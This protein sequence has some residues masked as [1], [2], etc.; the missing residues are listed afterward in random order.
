MPSVHVLL[1]VRPVDDKQPVLLEK[2][3]EHASLVP[4]PGDWY[5][6]LPTRD[7]VVGSARWSD[8][9]TEARVDVVYNARPQDDLQR[10]A[11]ECK[12]H[13]WR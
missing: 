10:I 7:A 13:G 12:A 1:I 6:I 8:D 5:A 4:R 9:L 11:K 2:I 3:V